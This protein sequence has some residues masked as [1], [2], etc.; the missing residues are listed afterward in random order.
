MIVNEPTRAPAQPWLVWSPHHFPPGSFPITHSPHTTSHSLPACTT[1]T[2]TT[3]R[4]PEVEK[5]LVG[6]GM[7]RALG[8]MSRPAR[9]GVR[10]EWYPGSLTLAL[11]HPSSPTH[12]H[13]SLIPLTSF[14]TFHHSHNQISIFWN[15]SFIIWKRNY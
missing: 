4:P 13:H 11:P 15:Y 2:Y 9:A 10:G 6:S 1:P 7:D 3:I 5:V 14:T 8:G 12:L